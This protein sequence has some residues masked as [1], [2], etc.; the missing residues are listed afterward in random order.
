MKII[1]LLFTKSERILKKNNRTIFKIIIFTTSL[2][3]SLLVLEFSLRALGSF[4]LK[5]DYKREKI[6]S[7]W[8]FNQDGLPLKIVNKEKNI[9]SL[10]DSFTFGGLLD[11]ES[12]YP[13]L[14]DTYLGDEKYNISVI[15]YGMCERTSR[16]V[17]E[18]LPSVYNFNDPDILILL[19]GAANRFTADPYY[20]DF[21][22]FL[23]SKESSYRKLR[24]YKMFR[25]IKNVLEIKIHNFF[26]ESQKNKDAEI[27]MLAPQIISGNFDSTSIK[28]ENFQAIK[29]YI[30]KENYKEALSALEGVSPELAA[31]QDLLLLLGY[32]QFKNQDLYNAQ[33]SYELAFAKY[34]SLKTKS[35][36]YNFYMWAAYS[37]KLVNP[38]H[39]M[40]YFLLA[41][42]Q[43]QTKATRNFSNQYIENIENLEIK[44][45]L[46]NDIYKNTKVFSEWDT[47]YFD[48][49]RA[50]QKQ[51]RYTVSDVSLV[52]KELLESDPN[53]NNNK[54]F[55][56]YLN[57]YENYKEWEI[58]LKRWLEEDLSNIYKITQEH[59]TKMLL[60]TYPANYPDANVVIRSFAK[61]NNIPFIDLEYIFEELILKKSKE[62]YMQDDDHPTTEGNKVIAT[63]IKNY[64]NKMKMLDEN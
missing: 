57:L 56:L 55:M 7:S 1:I 36:L 64:I 9:V 51:S 39:A 52:F 35:F 63:Q 38:A 49:L 23:T 61:K 47:F 17:L 60:L 13:A 16:D 25:H 46:K 5:D 32:L 37:I 4:Y 48:M 45:N 54:D 6:D 29:D 53:L 10:G 43:S 26:S 34:P 24:I 27:I 62:F 30:T 58:G 40:E 2:F 18:S 50:F 3:G 59:N 44:Q 28:I 19:V 21:N 8:R 12:T 20:S 41:L 11:K 33:K 14:L 42:K 22:D 31:D 15:N